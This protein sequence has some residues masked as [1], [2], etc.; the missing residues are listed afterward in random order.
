MKISQLLNSTAIA[1]NNEEK[2]FIQSHGE[3]VSLLSLDEHAVW[4]AQNLVRKGI[5]EISNDDGQKLIKVKNAFY[6]RSH[7]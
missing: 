3:H 4:L 1:L 7:L 5:Y 2:H 6:L